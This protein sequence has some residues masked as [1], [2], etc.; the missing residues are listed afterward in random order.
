MKVKVVNA[1]GRQDFEAK[2]LGYLVRHDGA[3]LGILPDADDWMFVIEER[4]IHL[5]QQD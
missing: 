5:D 4:F 3:L 1:P 2:L